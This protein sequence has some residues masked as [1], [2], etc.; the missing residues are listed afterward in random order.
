VERR[1]AGDRARVARERQL[2]WRPRSAVGQRLRE[3]NALVADEDQCLVGEVVRVPNRVLGAK[4]RLHLLVGLPAEPA[5]ELGR[6][7]RG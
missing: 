1:P 2:R 3:G 7:R 6:V 5:F 4:E